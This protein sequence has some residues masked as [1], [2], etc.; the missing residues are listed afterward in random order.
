MVT[1]STQNE[2]RRGEIMFVSSE[3]CTCYNL[4]FLDDQKTSYNGNMSEH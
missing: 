3:E 2:N 4:R 1:P